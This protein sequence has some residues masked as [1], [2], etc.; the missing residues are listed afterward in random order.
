MK[1]S[2]YLDLG[3]TEKETIGVLLLNLGG[4][5][6]LRS[7]RPFLYNLFSD[8]NIIRL[9][10]SFLQ[11][12][13]ACLISC[14]R[15]KKTEKMYRM[16]GGRSPMLDITNAQARF[17]ELA[18][19]TLHVP[20]TP[21]L[22]FSVFVGMRYWHPFI[23]D[24]VSDMYRD[25][26]RRLVAI[27]LYP[28]YSCATTGSALLKF[29]EVVSK[30]PVE[31]SCIASWFN[32][33]LYIEALVD[34]IRKGLESFQSKSEF[35]TRKPELTIPVLFSAHS[36][37]ESFI[38]EGDP[39]V[40]QI[41]GTIQEITKKIPLEWYLSYQSKSG[42][43]KWLEPSTEEMLKR[44]AEVGYKKIL[45]VPISFVS[46]HIETLFEIDI[47]YK[48]IAHSLGMVLKRVDSLNTHP[49]FIEALKDMVIEKA[50]EMG[51]A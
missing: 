45:I 25:S 21:S 46:D 41:K 47:I 32:H 40:H 39:Y 19:N 43:V 9:G 10:P 17:L 13:I 3:N 6:S 36:L 8:R 44:L 7:V 29:R 22:S 31:S 26:V 49:V 38:R 4:P 33:P 23:E 42:P 34:L 28:H 51:W 16:I 1:D 11:K 50:R 27:S 37:P 30:Y 5:D 12:P 20:L 24:V 15:S 18:L 14:V 35:E 2:R 48:E